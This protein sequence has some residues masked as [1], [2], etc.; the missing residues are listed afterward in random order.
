MLFLGLDYDVN[1]QSEL[2]FNL[3]YKELDFAMRHGTQTIFMGQTADVFKSRL[4]CCHRPLCFFVKLR[5]RLG[6][7]LRWFAHLLFPP[8]KPA[9]E[10]TSHDKSS[11]TFTGNWK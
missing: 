8:P 9:S 1:A 6:F 2:Y 3:C 5:G 11:R 7:L 4:R 10:T